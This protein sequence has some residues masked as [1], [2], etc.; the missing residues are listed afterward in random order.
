MG[1]VG[2]LEKKR[3]QS[4]KKIP[5]RPMSLTIETRCPVHRASPFPTPIVMHP[6]KLLVPICLSVGTVALAAPPV[7]NPKVWLTADQGVVTDASGK[8]E[9]WEDQSGNGNHLEQANAAKRPDWATKGFSLGE[10]PLLKVSRNLVG[11]TNWAG[12]LGIDFVVDREV[13]VSEMAVFDHLKDG[14]KGSV[15]VQIRRRTDGGTLMTP[16]D[17]GPGEVLEQIEFTPA[18]QGELDGVY[19]WKPLAAPRTLAPG[20]YTLISWG[21]NGDDKEYW[22]TDHAKFPP[23]DSGVRCGPR[24]RYADNPGDWPNKTQDATAFDHYASNFNLKFRPAGTT[25]SHRKALRFDGVDD[26]L[27]ALADSNIGR[28]STAFIVYEREVN[29]SGILLQNSASNGG[30]SIRSQGYYAGS[31]IRSG[32]IEWGR[33]HVSALLATPAATRAFED[34]GDVT[35][36]SSGITGGPGRLAIGGGAGSAIDAAA[37]KVAALL[38]YDRALSAEEI[39]ATQSYLGA[40]Y[41]VFAAEA[42]AP[43]ISP[44]GNMG[45]GDVTVTLAAV[46]NADSVRYTTDG[47]EPTVTSALYSAPFSVARGTQVRAKSFRAGGFPSGTS[48][49]YYGN[50]TA[51]DVPVAGLTMW[52]SG[53]RGVETDSSGRVA[54]WRDLSG[55]GNDVIQGVNRQRPS[56]ARNFAGQDGIAIRTSESNASYYNYSGT[57]GMDFVATEPLVIDQLGAFDHRGDGFGGVVNVQIWTRN[58]GGTAESP[59]DDTPGTLIAEAEFTA[60]S[61]GMLAGSSRYKAITPVNLPAGSYSILAWG[62]TGVNQYR[63]NSDGEHNREG[64]RFTGRSRYISANGAW[65]TSIDSYPVQYSG[66]GNFHYR[67]AS[68]PASPAPTPAVAFDGKDDALWA[69]ETSNVAR[70][71]SVFVAF[72]RGEGGHLLQN[73]SGDHW[74][75]SSTG[76]NSGEPVRTKELP[77]LK[78]SVATMTHGAAQTRAYVDG[79]D[80]TTNPAAVSG[81]PGRMALGGGHGKYIDATR[82]QIA[83]VLAFD[84]E[85]DEFERWRVGDYLAARHGSKRPALPSPKITPPASHGTGDVQVTLVHGVPGVQLRYTVDGTEPLAGSTLYAAPFSIPRGTM[86]RARAFLGSTA[87]SGIVQQYYGQAG[88]A[89]DL[90]VAGAKMWLRADAAVETDGDGKVTRWNDLSGSGNSLHQG[91]QA[92]RPVLETRAMAR[93]AIRVPDG[94]GGRTY[95]G[96]LGEDF[97]VSSPLEIGH[98]GAFDDMR[99]GFG[100]T[101]TVQLWSRNNGGTAA[102]QS[103]D[104]AGTMLAQMT[105]TSGSPGQLEGDMRYKALSSP[106]TLQPGAYTVLAWGYTGSNRY[107]EG[108]R[109]SALKDPRFRFVGFSRFGG[110][111]NS[112]PG[113]LD[114]AALDYNGAANF[115]VSAGQAEP[116]LHFDGTDD[117]LWNP[118]SMNFGR[119]S[120]VVVVFERESSQDGYIVQNSATTNWSIRGSGYYVGGWVAQRTFTPGETHI[121]TMTG[122]GNTSRAYRNGLDVTGDASLKGYSPGTLVLGGGSGANV[123]ALPVRIS[124]VVAYDRVLNADEL[125]RIHDHLA[126]RH[127]VY[128]PEVSLPV[129]SPASGYGEGDVAVSISG[130]AGSTIRY[131]ID[132]SDPVAASTAYAGAFTVPRGTAVRARAFADGVAPSGVARAFY[133]AQAQHPLPASARDAALW[134]RSDMGVETRADGGVER[135]R[136]LTGHG[137]DV[138]SVT[139]ER[140]PRFEA[141]AVGGEIIPV[142]PVPAG[143]DAADSFAGSVGT[144]FIV[145]QALEI[146]HLGAFDHRMDGFAGTVTVRVHRVNDKGTPDRNDD[147]STGILAT[148][149]FTRAASGV[150]EGSL[151]FIELGTPLSLEPGRYL[152]ESFG[153]VGGDLYRSA[154]LWDE[155]LGEGIRYTGVSRYSNSAATLFPGSPVDDNRYLATGSFKFRRPSQPA[156]VFS[157]VRFDGVDDGML[158]PENYLVGRPS[159]VFMVFKQ[160]AGADGRLL[161]NTD[162][163]NN[164]LLGPHTGDDG[165]HAGDWVGKHTIRRNVVSQAVAVQ[166][167]GD[168]RYFYN[169]QDLT[170]SPNS[171]GLLGRFALGGGEGPYSQPCNADLLELIIY[172]RVLPPGE[173]QQVSASLAARYGLPLEP[174]LPPIASPDGGL[175]QSSQTVSLSHAVPGTVIRYTTDGSEPTEASPLYAAPFLVSVNSTVKSKAFGEGY[176]P[177]PVQESHF[178][179]DAAAPLVPQRQAL[180]LWLRAGVGTVTENDVVSVWQDMSGKGQDAKQTVAASRPVLNP[181]AIGNAPGVVFDGTNDH[182]VMPE[183]FSDFSQGFTAIFVVRPQ[184]VGNYQRFLDLSRGPDRAGLMFGRLGTTTSFFSSVP[185]IALSSPDSILPA[186]NTILTATLAPGGD[187]KIFKNGTLTAERAGFTLPASIVRTFNYVGHSPYGQDADY[188][189]VISEILLFNRELSDVERETLEISVRSRYGI[190][191]S[192]TGIVTFSPDPAQLYP[193][194]VDVVLSSTTPGA[195]IHYTLDGS[196]PDESSPRYEGPVTLTGSKRVRARAFADGSNASR[197]SEATYYIGQPPS[198]G[199]GLLATYHDNQDLSGPSLTRVDST[200]NF[201]WGSGAPDPAID[202]ETFSVRWVGKVIPRFTEDYIFHAAMDDGAR[203]WLDLN[204]DGT[205]SDEERLINDWRTSGDVERNSSA[206]SLQAGQLYGIKVEMYEVTGRAAARLRWS[207]WSEPKAAIPQTQLF[208]DAPFSQTVSTPVITPPAGTYTSAVEVAISTATPAATIH[209]TVDGSEPDT[210]SQ[211]YGGTFSVGVDTTVRARAYK[212]GF[213]PSGV[214]TLSYDIDAQ[215]P[216]I[217]AFKWNGDAIQNGETFLKRGTLSVE[218]TDNQGLAKAEFYYQPAGSTVL[219]LI[220]TDGQPANG[221]TAGWD[222]STI[223]DGAYVLIARVYDTSGIWSEISRSI[224]VDL[225][226]PPAPQIVSPVSGTNVQDAVV[227]LRILSEPGANLR[228]FRDG[229]FVFAGYANSS[230]VLEYSASL[231]T[232]TSVFI[233]KAQNRAGLSADSNAVSVNRVREFPQLALGFDANTI[234][235]GSPVMGT[236]SLPSPAANGLMVQISTNRGSQLELTPQV[237]VQPGQSSSTFVMTARQDTIIE[238]MTT[239]KVTASAPEYRSIESELFFGDD[240][241]PVLTLTLDQASVS[242]DHGS[243]I[244]TIKREPVTDRALRVTLINS[245]PGELKLPASVEIPGGEAQATFTIPVV[246]DGEDDGNQIAEIRGRIV[247]DGMIVADSG[248]V[249]LEVRDN[250]GPA[251][252]LRFSKPYLAEGSSLSATVRRSG[253]ANTQ[254]LTVNLGQQPA[255]QL[256]LPA[257]VTIPAGQ[258]SAAFN[259]AAPVQEA[260]SG[261]RVISVRALAAGHTDGIAP[262]TLSDENK[263]ELTPSEL[264][265]GESVRSEEYAPV[266]YRVDNHGFTPVKDPF[267][268]RVFLSK[269]PSFSADDTLLRQTEFTGELAAGGHYTRNLTVLTPRL[270]GDYHLI[271]VVD[272]GSTIAELDETNNIA[273]MTRAVK[274]R[275]AYSVTVQTDVQV[276][277]ANTPVVFTGTATKDDG[278]PAPFSMVNIHIRLGESTRVISAVTNSAGQF[279]TT[280]RPLR[281]EGGHYLVGASHPGVSAAE[282]QDEFEILT[283]G[284]D[285]PP[286]IVMNENETV[287]TQAV[288]RNPN[289]RPLTGLALTVQDPPSGL[290]ITPELPATS[291]APGEEMIVPVSVTAAAGFAGTGAFPMTVQTA[292]GVTMQ[293]VLQ[294]RIELLKP[295]LSLEPGTLSQSVL[296]GSSKTLSFVI[297]NTGGLESGAIQL[298]LPDLPWL[299]IASENPIASIPPGGSSAVSLVLAPGESVP[300]TQYNGNLALN[301]ANGSGK[302]VP[303]QFRVVSDLKGDLDIEVTDEL[304]YF[305]PEAPKLAGA[306]VTVRDAITS[307][308]IAA[309]DTN[310][311]GLAR[312]TGLNEGWYRVEVTAPEH[313]GVSGNV[314]V[315]AGQQNRKEVFTSKQLVKY[316]WKVEEVEIED[317]YKVTMETQFETNV[318]APVVTASPNHFDVGDLVALGQ[319]KTINVTLENHGFIAAEQSKFRFSDHPFYEFTPL[320]TN[321]GTIPAKS[322]IVV[323]VTIRRVGVYGEDGGIVTLPKGKAGMLSKTGTKEIVTVPCGAG[324]VVDYAYA[325]GPHLLSK[326]VNLVING[327]AARCTS[328]SSNAG[329]EFIIEIKKIFR[330]E[331]SGGR[332]GFDAIEPSGGVLGFY[333]LDPCTLMCLSRAAFDCGMG[334]TPEPLACGYAFANCVASD[335]DAL[336]CAGLQ[337][338]QDGPVVNAGLCALSFINC[339]TNTS[340]PVMSG[341]GLREMA[342]E[343]TL[344][345]P[346]GFILE[347]EHRN[348]APELAAAWAR[349]EEALRLQ[350]IILGNKERVLMKAKPGMNKVLAGISNA[351][352]PGGLEGVRITAAETAGIQETAEAEGLDWEPISAIIVRWNRTVEYHG[353]GIFNLADVPEGESPDF[354]PKDLL[355]IQSQLSIDAMAASQA[356]GFVDPFHEFIVKLAE[357]RET[358]MGSQG[359]TCA[360]VKVQLSQDVMMTRTAFRA[361]LEVENEREDEL[362][363]VGFDLKVRDSLGQPAEDLFNIQ[364]TRITGVDGVDGTGTIGDKGKGTVQWTLIP[365]DTAALEFDTRYTVGGMIR[366]K[367]N[368]T[369]FN[370]PVEDVPITVKPDA[371]LDLK[372]FHQRDVFGD[373][374]HTDKIE[375]AQPYKLSVMVSNDGNGA[376]RNLK[377]ISGQPQIVDNEKGLFIDFKVIGTEVDGQ[378][379]SPSLTADFGTVAPGQKKIA[380]WLMTS[381]LQGLFTDYSAT[382]EHVSGM[383]DKRISLIKNVE[384]HEMIRMVRAQG[385]QD[386]GA[387]DFLVNDVADANDYPDTIHY[388]DGGTDLVTLRQTGIF[389]GEVTSQNLTVTVDTGSFNGWSYIRLPDPGQGKFRL[390]SAT[391]NDGRVLPLDFN[392]WQSDRTFIGNGRRPRNEAILHLADRDSAGVYTLKFESIAPEDTTPPVS[393]VKPLAAVSLPEIPVYWA[394][395]DNRAVAHYDIHVSTNGGPFVLWKDN[396]NAAGAIYRGVTGNTYAFYSIATDTAG[397]TEVK[398][399]Q[400]EASTE[401][402]AAN[403]APVFAAAQNFT[404]EEGE[405]FTRKVNATDPDGPSGDLRYAILSSQPAVVIHPV[406]GVI[407]WSTGEMDG[408][409]TAEVQVIATDSG[410]PA[411]SGSMAFSITVAEVNSPP[412]MAAVGPQTLQQNGVLIVDADAADGDSPAQTLTYSLA[413][414]PGGA[415]IHPGTGVLTWSPTAQQAGNHLFVIRATDNGN[416]QKFAETRFS[417]SVVEPSDRNPFFTKVPV[418]L[419]IK[420]RSY[421]VSVAATDPD[422][423]AVSLTAVTGGAPGSSFADQGGGSGIFSWN[424][425]SVEEGTYQVPLSAT[426]NGVSTGATLKIRVAGDNLYW[427][428]VKETFGELADGFDISLLEMDADPDGDGRGNVHEMALLTHPLQKDQVPV[429][430]SAQVNHPFATMNL[431]IHRRKGS[432][433]FVDLG[434]QKSTSLTGAWQAVPRTDWGASID[435]NGDDDGR[436]ETESVDFEVFEYHPEGMPARGFYRIDSTRK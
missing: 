323:P 110:S 286:A 150:L 195:K 314:Y 377:I 44:V 123:D 400:I 17:D 99:D 22:T 247:V 219:Q 265:I 329:D 170:Q 211:V 116:V 279:S 327:V 350:E 401:V 404:V 144:D 328:G 266:S 19:R 271:V 256:T 174:L 147:V 65:P 133:G 26:G 205:F 232:G 268:E 103:D 69:V 162:T 322:S 379:L 355:M 97:D 166:S 121:A 5:A 167:P 143:V 312:F 218:A 47:S 388:S 95:A 309:L 108:N 387:P 336:T 137:R 432:E 385:P 113:N 223:A 38:V 151:R 261:S 76:F 100:G 412:V 229:A 301:A 49:Q 305:T 344:A 206:V 132:G 157:A 130:S 86:V 165:F 48:S 36:D 430:F 425:A 245:K 164:W 381:T 368:G 136:D 348:F 94:S 363:E 231:P 84:R 104:T 359:G 20:S 376:A 98:L 289:E 334:F 386:D 101:V 409:K 25:I 369:Q 429:A 159:T 384:I 421:S 415:S 216:A 234:S 342:S 72:E 197:F 207:S 417:V 225:D 184:T 112:W 352:T 240:D 406:T 87:T 284:F 124:E 254:G 269:D 23:A 274:V 138:K 120:T 252:E 178:A 209:Y 161:L 422:G 370:I 35:V 267:I 343:E 399:A 6:L 88:A 360:R 419:W 202:P 177:S 160:L 106:L 145:D 188:S 204:R 275:A 73:T 380:T 105:F 139:A 1:I 11:T 217:S 7:P 190:S 270:T 118:E 278:Q 241:Y 320:V 32:D 68:A 149:T 257:S 418:V 324:G 340:G 311:S 277:P 186:S 70:P 373:D 142:V 303:Y 393:S 127:G 395:T 383:G 14:I 365:R 253:A 335:G 262:L 423:D 411:A 357:L 185:S 408:G 141:Q 304:T 228:I 71:S 42:T 389:S 224:T 67:K 129:I 287:A 28:P 244:G 89:D 302:A 29:E 191:S 341:R 82:S 135:W 331:V 4:A 427:N 77:N 192:A 371:S 285:A 196:A 362:G 402:G 81:M 272:A 163:A 282:D 405:V 264:F 260:T 434:V 201:D 210:T 332:D 375:P 212:A 319:T 378:P 125:K 354:I 50:T 34:L 10:Q 30:W 96:T 146:T 317:T 27:Q 403:M 156:P 221:M 55:N 51:P 337:M 374:P 214:A 171:A 239:L 119:P 313:D 407:T 54:R 396:T 233:A 182:F 259:I 59:E 61:P 414:G 339:F 338:C 46:I 115:K 351:R 189:G 12:S 3:R 58:D 53:D 290:T 176:L 45:T 281:N 92:Q 293:A 238:A 180:Q 345:G 40:E 318:P 66:S 122:D 353:R 24:A 33:P 428:W 347:E 16:E 424:T 426:A 237:Y 215:P 280:W 397:N 41:G 220:G 155:T 391:R 52:L 364:I 179:I 346:T 243:V 158:G 294:I 198:S 194:G 325:C 227:S 413:A 291:L 298:L 435:A 90:P 249:P 236:I 230:G 283:L 175:Y 13:V 193:Q 410:F 299:S 394:G 208:S 93:P 131:T 37:V 140:S 273:V 315:N 382:F 111:A 114:S 43:V 292:E 372:Y 255:G 109:A 91:M 436:G 39:H 169:G 168:S 102:T 154:D 63:N 392:V 246:D 307:A 333:S 187:A 288:L 235:E 15:T 85:L 56:V 321:I 296:R 367:Q 297:T 153:W 80:W 300:L 21:Y 356:A 366:Y 433:A 330:P 148:Q 390:I 8:V 258:E 203:L 18:S 199:D 74:S 310:A 31:W 358:L 128:V 152:I 361:T 173:R 213:N 200:V 172:D 349:V 60:A 416:P 75:I 242:E 398:A 420:G 308:Q 276:I 134:L 79:E 226:V 57:L 295:V 78:P 316:S 181:T 9:R 62:F 222:I 107:Y 306:R 183:G 431:R 263:P 64:L 126:A 250:E 326:A 83:E 117:A 248:A 2:R 251:L